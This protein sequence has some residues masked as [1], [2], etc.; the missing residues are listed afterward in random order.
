MHRYTTAAM[1]DLAHER[2]HSSNW[3][4]QVLCLPSWP[5]NE[6]KKLKSSS[7]YST[8]AGANE[9]VEEGAGAGAGARAGRGEC[10]VG[11]YKLNPVYP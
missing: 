1:L 3:R 7:S 11:L 9:M 8:A 6:N 5:M 2:G 10:A 4:P